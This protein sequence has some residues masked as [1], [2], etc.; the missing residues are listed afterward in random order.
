MTRP[1]LVRAAKTL[2]ALLVFVVGGPYAIGPLYRF[3][4]PTPFSGAQ[5]F[6]PYEKRIET[7]QRANF[8]AH[9]RAWR[10]VTNG[11]QTDQQVADRYRALGYDVAGVSNYQRVADPRVAPLPTYEHGYNL[12]K[13]HQLALGARQVEWFDFLLW[14]SP[15]HQQYVIDRVKRKSDLVAVVHP[16]THASDDLTRLTGYDLLEVVNGPHPTQELWD[17]ALS[18]GHPVWGIGNDD[19]HDL[20]DANRTAA[21]WT[22]VGAPTAEPSDIL[23]ALRA[24]RTYAVFRKG[25]L[26]AHDITTLD[27]VTVD[28]G[29]VTVVVNG[30]PSIITFFGQNGVWRDARPQVNSLSY[31]MTDADPYIRIVVE[32]PHTMLFLNPIVRW[33]GV[34]LA[35][36]KAVVDVAATWTLRGAIAAGLVWLAFYTRRRKPSLHSSGTPILAGAKRNPA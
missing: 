26:D 35:P 21:G 23:D 16:G 1:T 32:S 18:S 15:S 7:W 27:T 34:A 14:Q 29:T 25:A 17:A 11:K 36:P 10:G 6:N 8:H 12:F 30:A 31:T 2:A 24:G 9:G 20:N 5:L 33:N 13:L 22:M 4:E 28:N 3:P 19:I